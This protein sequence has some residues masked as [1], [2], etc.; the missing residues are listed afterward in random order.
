MMKGYYKNICVSIMILALGLVALIF[1]VRNSL[2]ISNNIELEATCYSYELS[3]NKYKASYF[4]EYNYKQY[5]ITKELDSKPKLSSKITLYCDKNN[6]RKCI[7]D[8]KKYIRGI[9]ISVI[10]LIP[11]IVFLIFENKRIKR[12][13]KLETNN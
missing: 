10:S 7:T 12:K 13:K 8:K 11:M 3:N 9:Y 2:A 5:Y 4:Y 6:I 1:I